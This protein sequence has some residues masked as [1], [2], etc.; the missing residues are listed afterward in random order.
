MSPL[1]FPRIAADVADALIQI[2]LV[3]LINPFYFE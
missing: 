2:G 1:K 3:G